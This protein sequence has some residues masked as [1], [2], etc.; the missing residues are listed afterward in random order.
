MQIIGVGSFLWGRF[1]GVL[2]YKFFGI[3]LAT[4]S[5]YT[6]RWR[7]TESVLG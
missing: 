6:R 4:G 3:D 5:W 7:A 2:N 1:H